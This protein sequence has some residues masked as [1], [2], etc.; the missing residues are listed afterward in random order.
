MIDDDEEIKEPTEVPTGWRTVELPPPRGVTKAED[1]LFVRREEAAASV[2][3]VGRNFMVEN[4]AQQRK[5]LM[6][7]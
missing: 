1:K 2:E 4:C 5:Y 3:A 7:W 6:C